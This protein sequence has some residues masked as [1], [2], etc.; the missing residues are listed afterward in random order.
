MYWTPQKYWILKAF[1]KSMPEFDERKILSKITLPLAIATIEA[2]YERDKTDEI[3][4]VNPTTKLCTNF[5]HLALI[6]CLLHHLM[7]ITTLPYYL[8]HR[9]IEKTEKTW[10]GY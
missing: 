7:R 6:N 1:E 10:M 4:V 2:S 5:A 9:K 8:T 3:E